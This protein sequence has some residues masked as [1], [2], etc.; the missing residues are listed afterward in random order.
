MLNVE[1]EDRKKRKD[2]L[3]DMTLE[4]QPVPSQEEKDEEN[5]KLM[6]HL[7]DDHELQLRKKEQ[8]YGNMY[9]ITELYIAR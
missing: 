6:M 3:T 7:Y 1:R 8:M 4:D 9:L 5:S 2:S